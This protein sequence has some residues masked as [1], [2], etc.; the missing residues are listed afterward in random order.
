MQTIIFALIC[1]P[2]VVTVKLK[3]SP[4]ALTTVSSINLNCWINSYLI[5]SRFAICAGL[6][7]SE[8]S[9]AHVVFDCY[10]AGRHQ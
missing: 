4:M 2:A 7:P 8:Y 3:S 1:I 9:Y 10:K 6:K 5:F